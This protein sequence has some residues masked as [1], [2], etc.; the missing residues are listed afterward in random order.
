MNCVKPLAPCESGAGSRGVGEE[1]S[2]LGF[3][4][5]AVEATAKT[6]GP[7][8]R[9]VERL[10]RAGASTHPGEREREIKS[11]ERSYQGHPLKYRG[12]Y[13]FASAKGAL[14][15]IAAPRSSSPPAGESPRGAA[16]DPGRRSP[17]EAE[18]PRRRSRP[19][20]RGPLGSTPRGSLSPSTPR[21][22]DSRPSRASCA[23][24]ARLSPKA[25]PRPRPPPI[26][27]VRA[28]AGRRPRDHRLAEGAAV[29]FG[30][31]GHDRAKLPRLRAMGDRRRG[32]PGTG[33]PLATAIRLV[34]A[35]QVVY[36]DPDHPS[37]VVLSVVG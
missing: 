28:R 13:S 15:S 27:S 17:T 10:A 32:N 36:H 23:A 31:A 30:R 20:P 22:G 26:G 35:D 5:H 19:A 24:S 34:A 9:P 16:S 21:S 18:T 37:S 8:A 3:L 6:A 25:R 1:A 33:E 4:E 29:V 12:W 11:W 14:R 7:R 2:L